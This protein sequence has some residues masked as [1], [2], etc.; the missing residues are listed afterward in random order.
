VRQISQTVLWAASGSRLI[1]C[2]LPGKRY[3]DGMQP[4]NEVSVTFIGS[5]RH[6][7]Q[8][9]LLREASLLIL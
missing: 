1:T 4:V 3:I 7:Q 9:I 8:N 6:F 2:P 5:D